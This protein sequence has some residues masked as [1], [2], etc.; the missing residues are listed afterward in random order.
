[1][2]TVVHNNMVT[3]CI[4]L[5]AVVHNITRKPTIKDD[6]YQPFSPRK[7]ARNNHFRQGAAN[8]RQCT[9]T[10]AL[11]LNHNMCNLQNKEIGPAWHWSVCAPSISILEL[12]SRSISR[13]K[14]FHCSMDLAT[15]YSKFLSSRSIQAPSSEVDLATRVGR[16]DASSIWRNPPKP[17]SMRCIDHPQW[18]V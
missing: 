9:V 7:T 18:F 6:D 10:E 11:G 13:S 12:F 2:V 14:W 8:V 4:I 5:I 3:I 17:P 16:R 15:G 1:M